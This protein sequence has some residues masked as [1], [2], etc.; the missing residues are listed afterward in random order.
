MPLKRFHECQISAGCF[1][2]KLEKILHAVQLQIDFIM[3]RLWLFF[4]TR[5]NWYTSA[6]LMY[7]S[8]SLICLADCVLCMSLVH[9]KVMWWCPPSPADLFLL[10]VHLIYLIIQIWSSLLP[11]QGKEKLLVAAT[12][13]P[14][15]NNSNKQA[16]NCL[17]LPEVWVISSTEV[18]NQ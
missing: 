12:L 16:L 18:G 9:P 13:T 14:I 1:L 7:C 5:E 10:S 3:I 17:G 15:G 6:C 4:H 11:K 8:F 2:H